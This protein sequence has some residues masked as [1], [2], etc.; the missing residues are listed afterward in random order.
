MA[1]PIKKTATLEIKPKQEE[2]AANVIT[3]PLSVI[4]M[5]SVAD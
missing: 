2:W 5:H 3:L 4:T 1:P